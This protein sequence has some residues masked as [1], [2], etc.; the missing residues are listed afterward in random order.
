ML[1]KALFRRI[2]KGV[3]KELHGGHAT[4]GREDLSCD[5]FA[6]VAQQ[7]GGEGSEV[8]WVTYLVERVAFGGGLA[9]GVVT[10]QG[11]GQRGVGERGRDGIDADFRREL[12]G[13][14][15][16]ETFDRSFCHCDGG[17][18][19]HAG[20]HRD[21]G[22]E[23]DGGEGRFFERRKG[24]LEAVDRSLRINGVILR[25]VR[26]GEAVKGLE[27]NGAREIDEPI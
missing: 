5:E 14:G 27:V 20:L 21:G 1:H 10:E 19:G 17:V 2:S 13:E 12:S 15:A 9:L 11:G 8:L 16:G 24:L 23:Y 4:V 7:K 6:L 26:A 18:V 22:E 25:K 3:L